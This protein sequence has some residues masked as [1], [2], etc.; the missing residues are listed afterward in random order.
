MEAKK[1]KPELILKAREVI[2]KIRAVQRGMPRPCRRG[3]PVIPDLTPEE[4]P[5]RMMEITTDD[6]ERQEIQQCI[7]NNLLEYRDKV[8]R[9]EKPA[10]NLERS[11]NKA[12][13]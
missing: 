11:R 4:E 5:E 2:D 12:N 8:V 1:L 6:I 13:K 3:I 7:A 10:L 9:T